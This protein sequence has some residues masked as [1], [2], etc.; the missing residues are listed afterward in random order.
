[1]KLL[2]TMFRLAPRGALLGSIASV[3]LAGCLVP[4]GGGEVGELRVGWTFGEDDS[5]AAVGVETVSVQ[6]ASSDGAGGVEADCLTGAVVVPDLPAGSYD[7]F[8]DAQGLV[9]WTGKEEL[10]VEAGFTSDEGIV[11]LKPVVKMLKK[12]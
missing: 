9:A 7:I 1:M 8:L 11:K 2:N 3:G 5:C 4:L 12:D 10:E 6:V